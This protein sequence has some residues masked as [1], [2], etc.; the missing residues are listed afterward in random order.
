MIRSSPKINQLAPF[1]LLSILVISLCLNLYGINWGLPSQW[2]P[3]ES[4]T[5]KGFVIPMARNSDP[6]PHNFLKPSFYYYFLELV[7]SPYYVYHKIS[8]HESNSGTVNFESNVTLISRVITAMIG[9]ASIVILYI[10]GRNTF[11]VYTGLLSSLFLTITMGFSTYSHFAYMDIPMVFLLL[12]MVAL[13]TKYSNT[14]KIYT[15]YLACFVGGLSISTKYN[16]ALPVILVIFICYFNNILDVFQKDIKVSERVKALLPKTLIISLTFVALGFFVGTPFSVLDFPTFANDILQQLY[17]S[18]KGYKGFSDDNALYRNFSYLNQA[19]GTPLFLLSLSGLLLG[20]ILLLKKPN[21]KVAVLLS[22]PF[23]YYL[24]ISTWH[25]FTMRYTLPVIPFL[26]L[27]AAVVIIWLLENTKRFRILISIVTVFVAGYSF[28]YSY[29]GV[30]CFSNDTRIISRNWIRDNIPPGSKIEVHG[31]DAYLPEFSQELDVK[32]IHP[33]FLI[34]SQDYNKYKEVLK[35]NTSVQWVLKFFGRTTD[36]EDISIVSDYTDNKYMFTIDSLTERNPDY[37]VLTSLFFDRFTENRN[38]KSPPY[39]TV[40]L[41]FNKLIFEEAGYYIIK[42][43]EDKTPSSEWNNPT[44]ILL[45]KA[46]SRNRVG[47]M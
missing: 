15:L 25:I 26:S 31:Y 39:P 30:R 3:D 37:I 17:I 32:R 40:S 43:F 45:K 14:N 41:F 34:P 5:I 27:W 35:K 13:Y 18:K 7:L 29:Q 38:G 16:S 2:H 1:L 9:S 19:L 12:L 21:K 28:V 42:V 11:N 24:Y 36:T 4:T 20:L 6:N 46:T 10:I 33:D 8:K 47:G 44:I 23:I 22:I